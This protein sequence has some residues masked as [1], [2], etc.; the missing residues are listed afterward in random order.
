[1][2]YN[3]DV[4]K[5]SVADA[6]E[7]LVDSVVNPKFLS[8]EVKEAVAKMK[9]DIATVQD[10]PQTLLLEVQVLTPDPCGQ[11]YAADAFLS[12]KVKAVAV[13]MEPSS[14][15]VHHNLQT[16]RTEAAC[17]GAATLCLHHMASA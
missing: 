2:A 4:P 6:V 11:H 12:W 5:P 9:A 7:I 1:M 15:S 16:V 13:E 3:I 17:M 10:N 8:W 14:L